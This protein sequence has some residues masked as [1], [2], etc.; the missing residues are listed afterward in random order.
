MNET[1]LSGVPMFKMSPAVCRIYLSSAWS[2]RTVSAKFTNAVYHARKW[3]PSW[4]ESLLLIY[5]FSFIFSNWSQELMCCLFRRVGECRR[6]F[7]RCVAVS[8]SPQTPPDPGPW[9][10]KKEK[11]KVYLRGRMMRWQYVR[12]STTTRLKGFTC[13]SV[14]TQWCC[15]LN[16]NI[17]MLTS[18]Q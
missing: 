10:K 6:L 11:K 15:Q 7:P 4:I 12:P 5:L 18:A 16:A 13:G 1:T 8:S 17:S 9:T 2:W 14:C 3:S